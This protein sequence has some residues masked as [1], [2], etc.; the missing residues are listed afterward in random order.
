MWSVNS[1]LLLDVF[2]YKYPFDLISQKGCEKDSEESKKERMKKG[3]RK[4][5]EKEKCG[6]IRVG[7]TS[8]G[9]MSSCSFPVALTLRG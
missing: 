1:L 8:L 5:W 3:K 2:F 4:K 9:K 7:H 6:V